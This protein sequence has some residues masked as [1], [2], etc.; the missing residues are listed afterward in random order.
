MRH[1]PAGA[2]CNQNF[3]DRVPY[4]KTGDPKPIS[5]AYAMFS[6]NSGAVRPVL[7]LVKSYRRASNT[8]P[9]TVPIRDVFEKIQRFRVARRKVF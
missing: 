8:R 4:H 9:D 5:G 1:S 2:V 7:M 3:A 6:L